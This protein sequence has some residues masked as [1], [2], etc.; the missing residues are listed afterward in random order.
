MFAQSFSCSKSSQ[1]FVYAILY[2]QQHQNQLVHTPKYL[3]TTSIVLENNAEN[4]KCQ[5]LP[6]ST[7]SEKTKLWF[8]H[9]V[10]TFR[11]MIFTAANADEHI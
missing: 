10:G 8:K 5:V 9:Q 6:S 7:L 2:K 3:K 4:W 1:Y 11:H